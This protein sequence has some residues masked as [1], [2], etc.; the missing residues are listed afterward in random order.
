MIAIYAKE[1]GS[2]DEFVKAWWKPSLYLSESKELRFE[3]IHGYVCTNYLIL[4]FT[5]LE[6]EKQGDRPNIIFHGQLAGVIDI[7]LRYLRLTF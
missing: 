4:Y 6:K 2:D 3:L 5:V 7:N 1:K